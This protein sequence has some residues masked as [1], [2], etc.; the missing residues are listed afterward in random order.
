MQFVELYVITTLFPL[1]SHTENILNAEEL[2]PYIVIICE[3]AYFFNPLSKYAFVP[4]I[5]GF[6]FVMSDLIGSS[7]E[8][9]E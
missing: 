3:P 2:N 6:L 9:V 1:G 4:I 5:S 7:S 8:C